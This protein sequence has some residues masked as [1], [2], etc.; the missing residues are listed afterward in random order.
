MFKSNRPNDNKDIILH[1]PHNE[2]DTNR[3]IRQKISNCI[4]KN[5]L[6]SNKLSNSAIEDIFSELCDEKIK[7]KKDNRCPEC[8]SVDFIE[9]Y[10]KG[11]V[12][13][14]YCGQVINEIYDIGLEKRNY[15]GDDDDHKNGNI[16]YNPLLPQSS[17]G[18][19]VNAGGKLRKLHNW[20]SMPYKERSDNVMFKKIH[21]VCV[22]HNIVKK[23]E[24]GAKNLCKKISGTLHKSGVNKGKPI[25]T[26]GYNRAG[27]VAACLFIECRKNSETRSTKEIAS[28]FKI[29]ERDINKGKR[30]LEGILDDDDIIKD[31]GTSK[32]SHFIKR[33]CDTLKIKMQYCNIAITIAQNIEKLNIASNHTTYSL[34]AASILLMAYINNLKYV[35]KKKLSDIFYGL[36]DVTIGKTLKQIMNF[37]TLLTDTVKVNEIVIDI[38][39]RKEKSII[40]R[41]IH[42]KMIQYGIDVSKY[43]LDTDFEKQNHNNE[44]KI[45]NHNLLVSMNELNYIKIDDDN[46]LDVIDNI[47][48]NFRVIDEYI[49]KKASMLL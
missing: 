7:A 22:A 21:D 31:I 38:N 9:D 3:K 40:T 30:S 33:K 41:D 26:R 29:S 32:V 19:G 46:L 10:A 1:H 35:T 25:I 47:S 28:Y 11:I 34:A 44:F 18:T 36:S 20:N 37:K 17:L 39:K 8:S 16:A 15:D 42:E 12:L 23:I 2:Y 4:R 5:V 6:A 27:I 14:K 48:Y 49:D 24:D 13:C 43:V 45:L